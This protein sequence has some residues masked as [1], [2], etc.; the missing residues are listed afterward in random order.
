MGLGRFGKNRDCI[1]QLDIQCLE[2][3][4]ESGRVIV[5]AGVESNDNAHKLVLSV[6]DNGPGLSIHEKEQVFE[7]FY[8]VE[9]R[10]DA[11]VPELDCPSP[12]KLWI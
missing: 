12:R 3:H 9:K 4:P 5:R 2:I 1:E 8:R 11:G 10:D 7:R 6:E